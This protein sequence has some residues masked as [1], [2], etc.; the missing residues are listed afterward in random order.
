MSTKQ[1]GTAL[2][3]PSPQLNVSD[4]SSATDN[5]QSPPTQD[6]PI[7][8]TSAAVVNMGAPSL[9]WHDHEIGQW[10]RTAAGS[11]R[12]EWRGSF[13]GIKATFTSKGSG[14][15]LDRLVS[16]G[17]VTTAEEAKARCEA[18]AAGRNPEDVPPGVSPPVRAATRTGSDLVQAVQSIGGD[19]VP[20]RLWIFEEA[21]REIANAS[22]VDHVNRILALA[23]GLAAAA[24]KATDREVEAEAVVLKFEAERKLGQL[25]QAQKETIGFNKGGRPKT[26]IPETPVSDDPKT[27]IHGIPVSEKPATLAEAGIG[28]TLAKKAR[29]AAA[30]YKQLQIERAKERHRSIIEHGCT[31]TDLTA[32]AASGKRFGVI[33]AD[34]PWPFETWGGLSG[35]GRSVENHYGTSGLEQ[36][37]KLPVAALAA[38]DC[39]LLMWCT[40]PHV[41]IGTHIPIIRPWSFRPCTA[42]F[43]WIKQTTDG[44]GLHIGMGYYTRS[45]SEPCLLAIKGSPTRLSA[46]VHQV[47]M[48]P[49][50]EHSEKPEEVRRRIERLFPGPYLELYGRKPAPGWTVWGNE[51]PRTKLHEAAE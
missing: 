24:R 44:D 37:A 11:Y 5:S 47:V 10:A 42:A 30:I 13:E 9:K 17:F 29:T 3:T 27:G 35:Q 40:W 19:G 33:Y 41:S 32:L 15:K 6:T 7:K 25:M 8:S 18:H 26:G 48:A 39:A 20:A 2:A 1:K 49:V 4:S 23:T 36:I 34:P 22:T 45:N 31:V 16:F 14:S 46:D 50:G 43:V 28:K 38:D 12:T 21:R 51:I